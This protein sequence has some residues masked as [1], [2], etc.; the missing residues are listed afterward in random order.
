MKKIILG[1]VAA[2]TAIL[3][4]CKTTPSTDT[5]Y[6]SS[7][8]IGVSAALVM[9][10]TKISDEDRNIIIDIVNEVNASVPDTNTTFS[11]AWTTIAQKHVD[12]LVTAGKLDEAQSKIIMSLFTAAVKTIDYVVYKRYPV[13]GQNIELIEAVTHGFCNGLLTYYTPANTVAAA[14]GPKTVYD[15]EAYDYM[16]KLTK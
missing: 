14:V 5:M 13:V 9:N 3:T 2:F 10:Q 6:S 4:G 15:K 7:Y 11:V 8:A 16:L 12:D 1:I